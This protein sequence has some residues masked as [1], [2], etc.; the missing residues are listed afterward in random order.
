MNYVKSPDF[1]ATPRLWERK[2]RV[3]QDEDGEADM[4]L[5]T[6]C[7]KRPELVRNGWHARG[8]L[9]RRGLVLGLG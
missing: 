8:M 3:L 4:L 7:R 6:T 2:K 1:G 9:P 5:S